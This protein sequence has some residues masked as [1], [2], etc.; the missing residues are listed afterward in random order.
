[1]IVLILIISCIAS[2]AKISYYP[3]GK[4]AIWIEDYNDECVNGRYI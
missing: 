1:M 3:N 2:A 4:M